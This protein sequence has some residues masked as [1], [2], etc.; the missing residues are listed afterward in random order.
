VIGDDDNDENI[1]MLLVL[2][3]KIY[4]ESVMHEG[5]DEN[6]INVIRS[7]QSHIYAFHCTRN[8]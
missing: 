4:P 7:Y 3:L 1:P 2:T 8:L 6:K 5:G